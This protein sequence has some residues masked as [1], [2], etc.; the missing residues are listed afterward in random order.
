MMM[1]LGNP[2]E[3]LLGCCIERPET[4][5]TL[6]PTLFGDERCRA[7]FELLQEYK[8]TRRTWD[9][10]EVFMWLYKKGPQWA[11][12]AQA[13]VHGTPGPSSWEAWER[14]CRERAASRHAGYISKQ[15]L[16]PS[17]DLRKA[18][19]ELLKIEAARS[20][21]MTAG[22]AE[23]V[24]ET[25]DMMDARLMST[26]RHAGIQTGFPRVDDMTDALT[27]KAL[28]I[29]A[30]S[31]SVGKTTLACNIANNLLK[32]D[33]AT[34]Y[35]TLEMPRTH[36]CQK[37]IHCRSRT[38]HGL[39]KRKQS[40]DADTCK[41]MS[42]MMEFNNSPIHWIDDATTIQSVSAHIRSLKDN[43]GIRVVIVDYL[44]RLRV[45]G[46]KASRWEDIAT[47][48]NAL[49]NI[50]LETDV[51]VVALSQISRDVLKE[52]RRPTMAD[53]KGSSEIEAD[54]DVIAFIGMNR[55]TLTRSI[56]I[57]K[58]RLGEIGEVPLECDMD[59]CVM[60]EA[61]KIHQEDIPKQ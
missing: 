19:K 10:C 48:S 60:E 24:R 2:E 12:L 31:P 27:E 25:Q 61:S 9:A 58:S 40:T 3:H 32:L 41:M 14:E 47:I 35:F 16:E 22:A 43:C 29:V 56:I 15:L 52:N 7:M 45:D 23:V 34:A 30:A 13:W 55:E 21:T 33:C 42:A 26:A 46:S 57:E 8:L 44:Q 17:P 1:N 18:S 37:M 50:A 54:A 36:I 59:K 20:R 4:L 53:L 5:A 28:W 11:E 51:T 39:F 38:S 49:K 6:R